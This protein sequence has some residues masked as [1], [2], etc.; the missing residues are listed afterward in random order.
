MTIKSKLIANVLLTTAIII[1]MSLSSFLSMRFLQKKLSYLT[2]KSTPFQMRSVEL[3]SELQGCVGTLA[4]VNAARTMGEYMALRVDA[5][6]FLANIANKQKQLQLMN[7][8]MLNVTNELEKN[9]LE[10]FDAVEERILD[11][12]AA[13]QASTKVSLQMN[14]SSTRLKELD[15]NIR[16]LQV[17]RSVA[18]AKAL[19]STGQ[20]SARL[21]DFEELRNQLKDLL[22][23]TNSAYNAQNNTAFLIAK[24]KVKTLLRRIA[25]NNSERAISS[26]LKAFSD[27]MNEFVQFQTIALA[28]KDNDSKNMASESL[29]ELL[30]RM[31]SMILTLNQEIELA[32]ARLIIE[33]NRQGAIF[34]QS[35]SANNILLGN[36]ELVALSLT[37]T[38]AVNQLFSIETTVE[39]DKSAAKIRDLFTKIHER[40]LS[41]EASLAKLGAKPEMTMLNA[42]HTSL[43]TIRNDLFSPDG[44]VV[45]LK[46]KLQAIDQLKSSADK[47]NSIVITQSAKSSESVTDAQIEQEKAIVAVNSM[48][49]RSL[50][51]LST[52]GILAIII[53][54]MFGFW[55]YRSVLM[56]LIVVL[57]AVRSQQEQVKEKAGLAQAVAGGDLSREVTVSAA[58]A[59]DPAQ[60]KHDEMGMV[61]KAI[62]AMSAAQVTLDRAF[63]EMTAS[64]RSSRAAEASRDHLK[65]GLYEL[66]TILRGDHKIEDLAA[67]SLAYIAGF[68]EAGVGILYLYD[69]QEQRLST[70]ST[71][72]VANSKR[73]TDG[74]PLGEGLPGQVALERKAISL[75]TV[76]PDYLPITSALG[77]SDPLNIVIMPIMHNDT[78]VGV[79]ELG[80]FKPFDDNDFDF[81][82]LALEGIAVA[83]SVNRSKRFCVID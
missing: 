36:S 73:L 40:A 48:V 10:L 4:K 22:T 15:T 28:K 41:E 49:R 21:R 76:P 31:N 53:G 61:L 13:S 8:S 60:I 9:S 78:L 65:S 71:Y 74:F 83:I 7:S 57:D 46:K 55:V 58:I 23:V 6:K 44:I 20:L 42:A 12:E 19:E 11:S 38:G 37:V 2:E 70:I 81:L 59:L 54:I 27:D 32:S 62:I 33:T 45:T 35:N 75:K 14:V 64:L 79:L 17:T 67:W 39:L 5:E 52:I 24:G 63:A 68:L 77:A 56:P 47:L 16:N 1:S 43:E 80:S 18:F 26:D 51:Q 50:S 29:K 66:N 69:A 82:H 30:E 72:A 25:G 34:S 3:Q